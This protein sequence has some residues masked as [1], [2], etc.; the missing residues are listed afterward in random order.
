MCD[1]LQVVV[2]GIL[3]HPPVDE[4]P[5]QVVHSILLV[6][7]CLR[8]NLG[9]EVVVQE[10]VKMRLK[11]KTFGTFQSLQKQRL[12]LRYRT[13]PLQKS[14]GF[15]HKNSTSNFSDL[16]GQRLVQE[17]L[18]EILLGTLTKYDSLA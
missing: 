3:R 9:V 2:V 6:L 13:A 17:L 15:V 11:R 14:E 18:E 12:Q 10:V 4:R 16:N 7:N 8:H 1:A 5:R